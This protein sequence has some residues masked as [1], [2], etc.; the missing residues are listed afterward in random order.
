M[1]NFLV[2]YKDCFLSRRVSQHFDKEKKHIDR[3]WKF[4]LV[5]LRSPIVSKASTVS[6]PEF[7]EEYLGE[8]NNRDF[9][10]AR[11]G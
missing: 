6:Q 11:K 2:R 3:R 4:L 8:Q 7:R 1:E 5:D 10:E 9:G